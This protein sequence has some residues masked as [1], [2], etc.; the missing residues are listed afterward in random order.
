VR[1]A[2]ITSP[3]RA[4]EKISVTLMLILSARQAVIAD[5]PCRARSL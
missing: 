4:S 2:S 1:N 5:R 3:Y